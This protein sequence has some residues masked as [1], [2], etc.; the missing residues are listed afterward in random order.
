VPRHLPTTLNV[1]GPVTGEPAMSPMQPRLPG[2][3]EAIVPSVA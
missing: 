3:D 1:P 2:S